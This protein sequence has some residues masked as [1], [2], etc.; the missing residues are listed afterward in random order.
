MDINRNFM[1]IEDLTVLTTIDFSDERVEANNKQFWI[2]LSFGHG[3][4]P[5]QENTKVLYKTTNF[6]SKK[7]DLVNL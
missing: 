7:N 3:F 1:R 2:P 5:L 6:Y 4:L